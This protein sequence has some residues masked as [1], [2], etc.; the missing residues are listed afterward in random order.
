MSTW[1]VRH[2]V[3]SGDA[4]MTQVTLILSLLQ[5]SSGLDWEVFTPLVGSLSELRKLKCTWSWK[6]SAS[7]PILPHGDRAAPAPLSAGSGSLNLSSSIWVSV[8][9]C[10]ALWR[11][12]SN[13]LILPR[14]GIFEKQLMWN[15]LAYSF[16]FFPLLWNDLNFNPQPCLLT[17]IDVSRG[18]SWLRR[19]KMKHSWS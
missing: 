6:E 1:C 16:S 18:P 9:W 10:L 13:F 17:L 4:G 14:S 8:Q 12:A 19:W 2:W 15:F 11:M 7:F 5:G 3:G